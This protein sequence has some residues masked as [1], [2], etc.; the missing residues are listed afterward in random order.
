MKHL[1]KMKLISILF[2]SLFFIS[3]N[4]IGQTYCDAGAND[5]TLHIKNIEIENI[6]NISINGV[7]GYTDFTNLSAN[8]VAGNSYTLN[9]DFQYSTNNSLYLWIDFNDDGDFA[10]L[11][12]NLV[13]SL[14][15]AAYTGSYTVSI[16][17]GAALG[18]HRMRIRN[19]Y[20]SFAFYNDPC[21]TA[22]YGE[23]EDYTVVIGNPGLKIADIIHDNY[24]NYASAN[25]SVGVVI[26]NGLSNDITNNTIQMVIVSPDG[27]SLSYTKVSNE[28]IIGS[29]SDT[30]YFNDI[31]FTQG[32]NYQIIATPSTTM[33]NTDVYSRTES[34]EQAPFETPYDE[35]INAHQSWWNNG[36]GFVWFSGGVYEN[37]S[38]AGIDSLISPAFNITDDELLLYYN[39][40]S[41]QIPVGD[42][43]FVQIA[44]EGASFVN[45]DTLYSGYYGQNIPVNLAQ[46]NGHNIRVQFRTKIAQNNTGGFFQL[47]DI[48]VEPYYYDFA[49][50]GIDYQDAQNTGSDS[51]P[52]KV[53]I[54]NNGNIPQSNTNIDVRVYGTIDTLIS[55]TIAD[56]ILA[57]ESKW[58]E[59][60]TIDA[61]AAGAYEI[62]ATVNAVF[63]EDSA[64]NV[65]SGTTYI[66]APEPLIVDLVDNFTGHTWDSYNF[67]VSAASLY[68]N[69]IA[70]GDSAT[71]TTFRI[72]EV[73]DNAKL[74]FD[75][76][77]YGQDDLFNSGNFLGRDDIFNVYIA[78][79]INGAYTKVAFM[80]SS[81]YTSSNSLQAFP[82]IDLS[83]YI[84]KDIVVKFEMKNGAEMDST[85]TVGLSI[86]NL[87]IGIPEVDVFIT[88][89]TSALDIWCGDD[90][91]YFQVN[92]SNNSRFDSYDVPLY[93]E[94]TPE[95]G[96]ESIY[97]M[98]IDTLIA[99]ANKVIELDT[100]YNMTVEG[101]YSVTAYTEAQFE[102]NV[103]N[104]SYN[105]V[106]TV[107]GKL[108]LPYLEDFSNISSGWTG[109]ELG[110]IGNA[111]V[112]NSIH[113]NNVARL[114]SPKFGEITAGTY[115]T[116]KY[117][118]D[119]E[120]AGGYLR[121]GD[122][123][124]VY[125]SSDCGESWN[126]VYNI[127]NNSAPNSNDWQHIDNIDLTAYQGQ[128][129]RAKIEFEKKNVAGSN[130]ISIDN[131]E[132]ISSGDAGI[133]SVSFPQ[134]Q[135]NVATCGTTNE[136]AMVVVR[137]FGTG[138][139][140]SI[141]VQLSVV[142][143][144][145]TTFINAQTGPI[146]AGSVDTI[147]MSGF[148][149]EQSGTYTII[150]QTLLADDL[151]NGNNSSSSTLITQALHTMP[152]TH[153]GN[154]TPSDW[155]Y[156]V[157][158]ANSG[159]WSSDGNYIYSPILE[160]DDTAY[161][162]TQK[163]GLIQANDELSITFRVQSYVQSNNYYNNLLR[164]NDELLVQISNDCGSTYST[165]A[166]FNS[167]NYSPSQNG[168]TLFVFPLDTYIGSEVSVRLWTEKKSAIGMFRVFFDKISFAPKATTDIAISNIYVE[169]EIC[170][171]V[172]ENVFAVVYNNSTIDIADYNIVTYIES[173][174]SGINIDTLEFVFNGI[175]EAGE[176][177]TIIVGSFNSELVDLYTMN[178]EVFMSEESFDTY[179][180]SFKIWETENYDYSTLNGNYD[181]WK[182]DGAG[183]MNNSIYSYEVEVNRKTIAY[184]PK[185]ESIAPNSILQFGY[186]LNAGIFGLGDSINIYASTDCGSTYIMVGSVT[187]SNNL[188]SLP[189]VSDELSLNAYTGQDVQFKV[190]FVNVNDASYYMYFNNFEIKSTDVTVLGI[191]TETD[192][193]VL[194]N[195]N[196][197]N[198]VYNYAERYITCGDAADNLIVVVQNTGN[199]TVDT[200]N[201]SIAYSGQ[202]TGVLT[203]TYIGSLLP[204][205]KVA[206]NIDGTIDTETS[207]LVNLL[208]TITV[209][210]D[211]V[212]SNNTIGY[213]VTTQTVYPLPYSAFS[214]F[215]EDYYWKYDD[216]ANMSKATYNSFRALNL[217]MGDTAYSI[218]PK[219]EI[220]NSNSYLA[221]GYQVLNSV[222]E[223][224]ITNNEYAEVLVSSD[225][226]ATWNS[227]WYMDVNT[228]EFGPMSMITAD[229][230]A[231][232]GQNVMFKFRAI[233]GNSNGLFTVTYNNISVLNSK[234]A[235]ITVNYGG[236]E[237]SSGSV[238]VE[239]SYVTFYGSSSNMLNLSY[240]WMLENSDTTYSMGN[241][242]NRSYQL[243]LADT[244]NIILK[245]KS[246]Y[247]DNVIATDTYAINVC[248]TP[249]IE[250]TFNNESRPSGSY[251]CEGDAIDLSFN[252]NSNLNLNYEWIIVDNGDT[253]S[254][255]TGLDINYTLTA[256]AA[257]TIILSLINPMSDYIVAKDY[258]HISVCETPII[259][260]MSD[261]I[262]YSSGATFCE[263]IEIDLSFNSNYNLALT[264]EWKAESNG[265]SV[266]IG[267]ETTV[268]RELLAS[269]AG[270]IKLYVY[271]QLDDKLI[272]TASIVVN[273]NTLPT[274]PTISGDDNV[275]SNVALTE[276]TASG[277]FADQ[278]IWDINNGGVITGNNII[279]SVDWNEGYI[280]FAMISAT[281]YNACG[282]G[283]TSN[284]Y[285][286]YVEYLDPIAGDDN[287]K[288]N[289]TTTNNDDKEFII[290]TYPNP[291]KGIFSVE[292]PVDV[293]AFE[294]EIK[295]SQGLLI[296]RDKVIGNKTDVTLGKRVPGL[297]YIQI[298]TNDNVYSEV[299]IIN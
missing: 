46:F 25:D 136:N 48:S 137:N 286:V 225:C 259:K 111:I 123:I 194:A 71:I 230:S 14:G 133:Q 4:A 98:I 176:T 86:D 295:N 152:Y 7:G 187:N 218:S 281:G 151:Y 38:T 125:L 49:V 172:N 166:T 109:S 164:D 28:T 80:D 65:S 283:T 233:K 21:G 132:V 70:R 31:D 169:D 29:D 12:E 158:E 205:A 296:Q 265:N 220:T 180:S 244:G 67:T 184:S 298:I 18:S 191:V 13:S 82:E 63:D 266:L 276:Y 147:Y 92:V 149:T 119:A 183:Y 268:S 101:N 279:G 143:G 44:Q 55:V 113:Y 36:N 24:V 168:D 73:T 207:G 278:Y 202:S 50:T 222:G 156:F 240:E 199:T 223:G 274:K 77:I 211:A 15:A 96:S 174:N 79:D 105:A 190:E 112:T 126:E 161:L 192:K 282:V 239:N 289:T 155:Q 3:Q 17:V 228:T 94:Y 273:V 162:A 234:P 115:L 148:N 213:S 269:D 246:P 58:V 142:F 75:Y 277:S 30:I 41:S 64:N 272:V 294:M 61:R 45:F 138:N 2:L 229:L 33:P 215:N 264:Y 153:L 284:D 37:F 1:Y 171:K 57:G 210:N 19:Q 127:N 267:T 129:L 249:E 150:A 102:N 134:H 255:G 209:D 188:A 139:L 197:N 160:E 95:T 250:L 32:G 297:Y 87:Y 104:D 99:G 201:V 83:A 167:T 217:S 122:T 270:D 103:G 23:V 76:K 69:N 257:G 195:Y 97:M 93:F 27:T 241:G 236:E 22:N 91:S 177:D 116:F 181:G 141:P 263:S 224:H 34:I 81:M 89:I 106:F 291:N 182:Y 114:I 251:F 253:T 40:T 288:A 285:L 212:E 68:A 42:T 47:Y 154:N 170:G 196:P 11:N 178:S 173:N 100:V 66:S 248:E 189:N 110:L 293:D 146:S 219:V 62:I 216:D 206:V 299:F 118:V 262:E 203:G 144:L 88:N 16:P 53:E 124:K 179:S 185:I 74:Y 256:D 56:E 245:V 252:S 54:T 140:S 163:V 242:Y 159:I 39:V 238:F 107:N 60:G 121:E 131:F 232:N 85:Y 258:Y 108:T 243:S 247:Y 275:L 227:V 208:A 5:P 43:V 59:V 235:N 9:V 10:D 51:Y 20:G 290:N 280:G 237:H 52:I 117:K 200:V 84:G 271:S 90:S 145:D 135:S 193:F 214:S 198:S 35:H 260:L 254:I 186:S 287:G 8:L 231:Y 130:I 261:N 221:F 26:T 204:G 165:V 128:D 226:G 175:L 157:S 120:A 78:E 72:G 6:N 292:L